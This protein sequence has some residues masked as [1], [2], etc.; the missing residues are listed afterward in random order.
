MSSAAENV[1]RL[2]VTTVPV[3]CTAGIRLSRRS[4]TPALQST[5]QSL[6]RKTIPY[7]TDMRPPIT[8]LIDFPLGG[9]YSVLSEMI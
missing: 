1:E 2:I 8:G 3:A 6:R 7:G 9:D 4:G 5:P